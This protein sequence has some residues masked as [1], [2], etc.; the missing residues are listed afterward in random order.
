VSFSPTGKVFASGGGDETIRIW[1]VESKNGDNGIVL[2][3]PISKDALVRGAG[4]VQV[5][6][7]P[8]GKMLV[9]GG[10]DG[11]LRFWDM[12]SEKPRLRQET[13]AGKGLATSLAFSPDGKLLA[14]TERQLGIMRLWEIRDS[15]FVNLDISTNNNN[16]IFSL[17][18]SPDGKTLVAG[19]GV[20]GN[21]DKGAIWLW[22]VTKRPA[23]KRVFVETENVPRSVCY[24]PD[25]ELIAYGDIGIVRIL[26]GRTGQQQGFF[27]CEAASPDKL[28]ISVKFSP[29]GRFLAT[30]GYDSTVRIWDI[31]SLKSIHV[32]S[33]ADNS[34]GV[35]QVDFSPDGTLLVSGAKDKSV[36][37]WNLWSNTT[38]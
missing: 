23:V 36:R 1:K 12:T 26:N 21:P 2:P 10:A 3:H 6:F 9:S 25:G 13:P 18:F 29:N 35:E 31:A 28:V 27:D 14:A 33:G 34:E 5:A 11:S 4:V 32:F 7:V 37:L 16:E 30:C 17:D 19:V 38:E 8:N 22:D 20:K 24:S 15:K